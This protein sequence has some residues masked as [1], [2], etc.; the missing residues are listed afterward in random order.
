MCDCWHSAAE[1]CDSRKEGRAARL[2]A[3]R[4]RV[5][6]MRDSLEAIQPGPCPSALLHCWMPGL[7][8]RMRRCPVEMQMSGRASPGLP[9]LGS[10]CCRPN[11]QCQ[12][13]TL[14]RHAQALLLPMLRSMASP[15]LSNVRHTWHRATLQC[16]QETHQKQYQL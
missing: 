5:Q 16:W 6:W 1:A 4:Q 12:M 7:R 15:G 2:Q 3:P 13:H 11:L 8:P 9:M 10:M 14:A